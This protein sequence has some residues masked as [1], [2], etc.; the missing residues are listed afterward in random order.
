MKKL[1][2]NLSILLLLI[3]LLGCRNESLY[4]TDDSKHQQEEFIAKLSQSLSNNPDGKKI[5]ERIKKENQKSNFLEKINKRNGEAK[6]DQ[7]ILKKTLQLDRA[8]KSEDSTVYL[9][10]PF[11]NNEYLSSVL[12][13]EFSSSD[14]NVEEIDNIKLEEI[15]NNESLSRESRE[16]LLINYLILDKMQYN[17]NEYINIPSTLFPKLTENP[18]TLNKSFKIKNYTITPSSDPNG[19]EAALRICIEYEDTCSHCNGGISTH[20]E[21]YTLGGG[22]IGGGDTGGTGTGTGT[23]TGGNSGNNDGGGG[24]GTGTGNENPENTDPCT[25][26]N[27]PWYTHSSCGNSFPSSVMSLAQKMLNYGFNISEYLQFLTNNS[28]IRTGFANYLT[29]NNNQQGAD[30]VY[31]GLQFFNQNQNT[32]WENFINN[33]HVGEPNSSIDKNDNVSGGYDNTTYNQFNPQQ[34]PWPTISN[35]I[36]IN[37]FIGWNH[38]GIPK[39]CMD[40][41]KAQIAIKGYQISNYYDN[42]QTF[43][44]Y[45]AQNGVNWTAL[46]QGLSYLKY[47]LSNGIPVI[48]GIDDAPGNPGNLDNTTDHFVV[49]VGMGSDISGNYFTFYD[50]ADNESIK[51]ASAF[52]KMY[53]N[54]TSGLIQGNSMTDYAT[55]LTYILTQIRKSKIK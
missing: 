25:D 45:T 24:S 43:Q 16:K 26:P 36:S 30:F 54:S 18:T 44:I 39:N 11:G 48:V 1:L 13:I 41:A 14:F 3:L 40:Y 51:G 9:N 42:G 8:G 23:E 20:W 21:C 29:T 4:S 7:K 52:N 53:Y 6:F 46:S 35:I 31:W 10:I 2:Q 50:N 12:F 28:S 27:S 47:A 17:S 22:G 37:N 5:I 49:I 19:R 15:V 33:K 55:G 32:T 34:E 38:P